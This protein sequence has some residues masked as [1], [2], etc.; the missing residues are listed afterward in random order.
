MPDKKA[1]IYTGKTNTE[2]ITY[3]F[4][5]LKYVLS[6]NEFL[7]KANHTATSKYFSIHQDCQFFD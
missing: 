4:T 3:I 5:I 7:K 1:R 6:H 2:G